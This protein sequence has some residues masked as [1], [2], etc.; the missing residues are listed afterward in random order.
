[1]LVDALSEFRGSPRLRWGIWLILGILWFYGVLLLRDEVRDR[2]A[3]HAAELRQLVRLQAAAAQPGWPD[4]AE[5]ARA[6]RL[7]LE[8][9][10]WREGTLGLAQAS[11][12]DWVGQAASQAGLARPVLTVAAQEES[13]LPGDSAVAKK[14][15]ET[16]P[17]GQWKVTAKVAFEFRA[18][19]LHQFLGIVASHEKMVS[20]DSVVIR[21]TPVPRAEIV[22]IAYYQKPVREREGNARPPAG[23]AT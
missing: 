5:A 10:M 9:R 20:V 16:A 3:A 2:G 19:S 23:G 14:E 18:E 7:G 13:A 21:S 11:F 4:R 22:L 8:N 17:A 6:Q 1:M 12:Q 15:A